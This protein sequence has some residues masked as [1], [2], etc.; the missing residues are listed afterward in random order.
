MFLFFS[1]EF[2]SLLIRE[3]FFAQRLRKDKNNVTEDK[4]L[5]DVSEKPQKKN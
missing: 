1:S 4:R 2:S 3:D 5:T